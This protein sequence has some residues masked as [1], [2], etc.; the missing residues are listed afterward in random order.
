MSRSV[1]VFMCELACV[2]VQ[3]CGPHR[4]PNEAM[5]TFSSV[6]LS[7]I[8]CHLHSGPRAKIQCKRL[9]TSF[10]STQL[11]RWQRKRLR[12]FCNVSSWSTFKSRKLSNFGVISFWCVKSLVC[13]ITSGSKDAPVVWIAFGHVVWSAPFELRINPCAQAS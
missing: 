9:Y 10:N 2:Y 5:H 12:T 3:D 6:R 8:P 13:E 11:C 4:W 7:W 1:C